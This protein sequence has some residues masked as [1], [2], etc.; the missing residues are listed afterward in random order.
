MQRLRVA[1]GAFI[2]IQR[3]EATGFGVEVA[4]AQEIHAEIRIPLLAGV[5]VGVGRAVAGGA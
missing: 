4:G 3:V 5:A 2:R 1:A